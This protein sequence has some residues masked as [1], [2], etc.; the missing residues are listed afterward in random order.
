VSNEW[1][2]QSERCEWPLDEFNLEFC[3]NQAKAVV[4]QGQTLF[5]HV[6]DFHRG[7]AEVAH[8]IAY[9]PRKR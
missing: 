7:L 8:W 9:D 6:C 3:G 2:P 5:R 1:S 4:V